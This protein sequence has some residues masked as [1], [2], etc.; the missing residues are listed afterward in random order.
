MLQIFSPSIRSHLLNVI[1]D[2][3]YSVRVIEEASL[4]GVEDD[5]AM[6]IVAKQL[7]GRGIMYIYK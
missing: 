1:Y 6:I 7:R 2:G 5:L 4:I 3:V